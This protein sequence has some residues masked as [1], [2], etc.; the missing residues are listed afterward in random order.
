[1]LS[2]QEILSR[3]SNVKPYGR[4]GNEFTAC[5]P[6]HNSKSK[7]SLHIK[8]TPSK[9]LL[10]DFGCCATLDI[11]NEAGLTLEDIGSS[12]K[13]PSYR[14][15][16]RILFGFNQNNGGGWKIHDLYNY[17]DENGRYLYTKIRY[18]KEGEKK[19]I[20][21]CRVDREKDDYTPGKGNEESTLYNLKSFLWAVG[22]G[23]PVYYVEGEKDVE[24][25]KEHGLYATSAGGTNDWKEEFAHYFTGAKLTIL[26][27]NDDP[28]KDLAERI[29]HDVRKYVYW[30]QLLIPSSI[31]HGDVTDYLELEGGLIEDILSEANAC[32]TYDRRQYA[33]W[34]N[35]EK[36][37]GEDEEG[38][39][40]VKSLK[41]ST[42]CDKLA[43]VYSKGNP[44]LICRRDDDQ[45][46]D[47]YL[48]DYQKGVYHQANRNGIKT[49]IKKYFPLGSAS[50]QALNSVYNLLFCSDAHVTEWAELNADERHINLQNGIYDLET[51]ELIPHTP[52]FKSTLQI[53]AKYLYE[54]QRP[55]FTESLFFKYICDLCRDIMGNV[56]QSRMDILQEFL[57]LAI[58]NVNISKLKKM[59]VLFSP[60]GNSGKS[61]FLNVLTFLLGESHVANVPLQAMN[62]K[63]R[64][65]LGSL[66]TVRI[67]GCGDQTG[68]VVEDSSIL[69][70]LTGNDKV[71]IE[72]KGI[73]EESIYYHGGIVILCNVLPSFKDDKGDHLFNRLIIV[74]CENHFDEKTADINLTDKLKTERDIILVWALEGLHRLIKNKWK[75]SNCIAAEKAKQEYRLKLD[76]ILRFI[77][78][79]HYIITGNH[80][81]RISKAD[82]E[83][84][85]TK[86]CVT[87]G[88]TAVNSLNIVQRMESLG[89]PRDK[90]NVDDQ[91][92]IAIYRKIKKLTEDELQSEAS[93]EISQVP[94]GSSPFD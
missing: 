63:N 35:V 22:E 81:D 44:Y 76:S 33:D 13:K 69:K 64:F 52:K 29:R 19:E 40:I 27:D 30:Q 70:Q 9:V 31:E 84:Q 17:K 42:N 92:G 36:K 38:Q 94:D 20:R 48:Y 12:Q 59:L 93:E 66:K 26:A 23:L 85:Y 2:Q 28:G 8:F 16:E 10:Y 74:P 87:N 46:D 60:K 6:C 89:C 7:K 50:D 43:N 11:L 5:C 86:W 83:F 37:Y 45:K 39:T 68:A 67:L 57:G 65:S 18:A 75:F 78:E 25:L 15:Y 72:R 80:S 79:N 82:F 56:D 61:V 90:G 71:K 32:E 47:F 73:Q 4:R 3:F 49:A 21:Y 51:H 41:L 54:D 53:N 77:D 55:D 88:Y 1:M 34:L 14:W 58:S 62:E 91:R 24:T